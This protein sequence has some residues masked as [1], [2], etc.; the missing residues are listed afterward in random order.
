MKVGRSCLITHDVEE[1]ISLSDRVIVLSHRPCTVIAEH[2]I[3]L[4]GDRTD[5]MAMRQHPDF[6]RYVRLI[7]AELDIK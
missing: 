7:W 6:A 2:R 3:D 1:A 5:M 4:D